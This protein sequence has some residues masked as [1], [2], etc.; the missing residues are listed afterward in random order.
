MRLK[1]RDLE[2]LGCVTFLEMRE[3]DR[4]ERAHD[5][6]EALERASERMAATEKKLDDCPD[7][8]RAT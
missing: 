3:R 7:T 5:T 1:I 6:L 4:I 2:E 8:L